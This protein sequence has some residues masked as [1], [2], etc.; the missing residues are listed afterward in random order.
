[1]FSKKTVMCGLFFMGKITMIVNIAKLTILGNFPII[2]VSLFF[3]DLYDINFLN[4]FSLFFR[5][6]K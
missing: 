2:A 3:Q 5:T 1:M 4:L 6:L